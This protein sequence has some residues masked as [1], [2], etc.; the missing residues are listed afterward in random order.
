MFLLHEQNAEQIHNMTI[1]NKPLE[2]LETLKKKNNISKACLR[3][4][5]NLLCVV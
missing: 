1:C 2:F 5:Q 4:V 3:S